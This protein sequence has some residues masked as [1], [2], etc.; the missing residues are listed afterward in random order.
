MARIA[1]GVAVSR[2]RGIVKTHYWLLFLSAPLR[3]LLLLPSRTSSVGDEGCDR[4]GL[5][6]CGLVSEA[7]DDEVKEEAAESCW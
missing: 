3:L 1:S 7:E 5:R 6:G 4:N 2:K